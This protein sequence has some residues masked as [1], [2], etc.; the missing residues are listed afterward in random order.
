MAFLGITQD[1]IAPAI[2]LRSL[3]NG[4]LDPI[5]GTETVEAMVTSCIGS[6]DNWFMVGETEQLVLI[7]PLWVT[8]DSC[9]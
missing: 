6:E 7:S 4:L 9:L 3:S 2:K 5:A 1:C 8:S